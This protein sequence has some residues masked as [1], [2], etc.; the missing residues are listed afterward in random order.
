MSSEE[1][2]QQLTTALVQVTLPSGIEIRP[3][4]EADFRY[5]TGESRS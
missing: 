3:W 4:S 5:D 1:R 2:Q